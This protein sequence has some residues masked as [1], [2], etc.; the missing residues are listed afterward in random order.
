MSKTVYQESKN[1]VAM[2]WLDCRI[3]VWGEN[4]AVKGSGFWSFEQQMWTSPGNA[5]LDICVH[6]DWV[7]LAEAPPF[8]SRQC[9]AHTG[10]TAHYFHLKPNYNC[11]YWVFP[12]PKISFSHLPLKYINVANSWIWLKWK[13]SHPYYLTSAT[14]IMSEYIHLSSQTNLMNCQPLYHHLHFCIIRTIFS[15]FQSP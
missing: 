8:Q 7:R 2:L 9:E 13:N 5:W 6:S 1:L 15:F 12:M 3:R 4:G 14:I 11:N 10:K